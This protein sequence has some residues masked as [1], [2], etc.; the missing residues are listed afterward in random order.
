MRLIA[1]LALLAAPAQLA[2]QAAVVPPN[3]FDGFETIYLDNG[4]KVWYRHMPGD[5]VVAIS[6]ALPFGADMDPPGKEQL[7][8]FTEHML[9]SDQPGL[10]EEEIRREIEDLGGFYNASVTS[11]RSFYYVHIGRDHAGF[12][13]EWLARIL[14]PHAMDPQVVERQ[15]EPVALEVR[16]RPRQLFDWLWAIYLYPP[17]LRTPGFWEREFGLETRA[18]RD[19]YPYASLYSITAEDLRQF[20]ETYYVPSLMTLTVIGDIGRDEVMAV[21][22][23]TFAALPSRPQP[24]EDVSLLDPDRY[25]QGILWAYRSNVYYANRYK[26][27]E[28]T[29]DEEVMLIFVAQLLGK[30]LN[31]ALRFGERKATYGINVGIVKR[32]PAAY[33]HVTGGIKEEEFEFARGVVDGDLEALRTGTLPTEEFEADKSAVINQLRVSNSSSEGL[34]RWVRGYFFD[35][36]VHEDYPDLVAEFERFT[37]DDVEA[38]VRGSLLRERQVLTIVRP[39]PITQG[40]FVV[41]VGALTWMAIH[42]T[43]QSLL[44]PIDMTRMRYVARFA[45][46]RLFMLS[47]L[48]LFGI[49]V[50]V[51]GR[52]IFYGFQLLTDGL[53]IRL[54]SFVLQWAAYALMLAGMIALFVLALAAVPRKLLVFEDELRVKYLSYR[55]VPI[56][57]SDIEEV[58]LR[59]FSEVW[60]SSR[61]WRCL[62]LAIGVFAPAIYLRSR[63]GRSL[64]FRSR[65]TRELFDLLSVMGPGQ[66]DL[67]GQNDAGPLD[68]SVD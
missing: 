60:L 17:A 64:Y 30:R 66:A 1:V 43:R 21:I 33:L 23:K 6:V 11:D 47:S 16:A 38:F 15:R 4:L 35:P 56:S 25:W 24:Q 40:L 7:A 46:P 2:A 5:P 10:S 27:Y 59:R 65:D 28:L 29:A 22:D 41:L 52:L 14:A 58:S 45:V 53:L 34:E 12:G 42:L 19:Y 50:A 8:H 13:L 51:V 62:P 54:D 37:V 44:R 48:L 26:F 36:R 32:G 57:A 55:S 61:L 20:Y 3:P 39:H 68:G 67:T 63:S 49:A 31:E 18:A 9:F